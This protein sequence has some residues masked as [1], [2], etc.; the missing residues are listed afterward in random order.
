MRSLCLLAALALSSL[1]SSARGA[2]DILIADFEGDD[3]GLWAVEGRAFGRRPARG[4]LPGQMDVSGFLGSGLVNSFVG[5]DSSTGRLVSPPF[6]VERKFLNFLIGG[7]DHPG[8]TCINLLVDG[9]VVRTAT[10]PNDAAGGTERLDWHAWDVS[11]LNGRDAVI[12]IIDSHTGGW[13]HISVDHIHQSDATKMAAPA[14]RT[15]VARQPYLWLPVRNGA[16]KRR[17]QVREGGEIRREFEIELADDRPDFWVHCDL[18]PWMGRELTVRIDRLTGDSTALARLLLSDQIPSQVWPPDNR[19]PEIH[20]TAPRGW[21]NDPNGMVFAEGEWHL[22]YQHNPYGWAWGNMH[23]GH[24]VSRNLVDWSNLP[25]A[26]TP[27]RFG[28]WA[29]SG[30]AVVDEQNTSGW[31]DGE[32]PLLVAAYTST[33]RGECMIYSNDL[34]RTWT[35]YAGNPVVKHQGRDPRLLWHAPTN[36]WVMAV[37]TEAEGKQWIAFHHSPDL[38]SWTYASRIEGYFECPDLFELPVQGQAGD[39]KWVLYAADG[40][41][42]LG[43]FDGLEFRPDGPKHQLW[44]GN[45]Y[46][47]QTFSDAPENRRIQIGWGQGIE[48]PGRPYNQQMTIPVELSLH[49]T[50]DGVRMAAAPVRELRE[51]FGH[52]A[53][54]FAG[55]VTPGAAAVVN[56]QFGASDVELVTPAGAQGQLEVSVFGEPVVIDYDARTVKVADVAPAP[57]NTQGDQLRLRIVA[58]HGSLEAFVGEGLTAVSAR[59]RLR[60]D[61]PALLLLR[62]GEP[63]SVDATVYQR[64]LP[65][66]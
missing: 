48:F 57:W 31:R 27:V 49:S 30:S 3:Y 20:F 7:G 5:G 40:R 22:Y 6:R 60:Q 65:L 42:V 15:V 66:P 1:P 54:R 4:A 36:R 44:H 43:E 21:L 61:S 11:D 29:F 13:G 16:T 23:W 25:I 52:A 41:Y 38:K 12:E 47:A 19:R 59:A 35:E 18:T 56:A 28:D 32:S 45:F 58:D 62:T 34:G 37:Y 64:T 8:E 33:G 39:S 50:P 46:A 14:E 24:A 63:L 10:G 26:L 53:A 51:N 9:K 2:D 17:I 55:E